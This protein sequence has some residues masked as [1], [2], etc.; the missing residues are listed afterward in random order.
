MNSQLLLLKARE[1]LAHH[2]E[3]TR[4]IT[5]TKGALIAIEAW[6]KYGPK[7]FEV[8][9]VACR[10]SMLWYAGMIGQP[11]LI[12]RMTEDGFWAREPGGY[13]NIIFFEDV[14]L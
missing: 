11:I 10:D 2:Q 6:L 9:I 5:R 4:P 1:A 3:Q 12:E 8:K 7:P 13:I 14:Q